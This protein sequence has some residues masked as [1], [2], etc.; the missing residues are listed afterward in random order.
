MAGIAADEHVPYDVQVA[1]VEASGKAFWYWDDY[2][3]FLR[4]AGVHPAVVQRMTNAGLSKYA[5]MRELLAELDGTGA[6]GRRVQLQL[7]RALVALPLV[8]QNGVEP[9]EAKAAQA[10]LRAVSDVHG[11]L[12]E[13]KAA[14]EQTEERLSAKQTP[15]A[16]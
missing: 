12:P 10:Q 13:T 16:G 9:A 7:V 6:A 8:A 14:R 5:V 11:L 4:K 2:R 3:H 1:L 15:R